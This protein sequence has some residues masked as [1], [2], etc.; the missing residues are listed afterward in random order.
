MGSPQRKYLITG[1]AGFI[2]SNF[3]RHLYNTAD[4]I[5]VCVLDKLTYSG[6]L[7]NLKEFE[8]R[9]GFEFIKGDICDAKAVQAAM[10][11]VEVGH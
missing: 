6:N 11:G 7:E 1:G 10:R 8:G 2:G 3:V 4:N 9:P 5:C